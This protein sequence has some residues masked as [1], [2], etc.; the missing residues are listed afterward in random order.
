MKRHFLV[1]AFAIILV[2]MNASV[3]L[4]DDFTGTVSTLLTANGWAAHSSSGSTPM[5]IASP[6]LAYTGYLSSGIGNATSA[7]ANGEDVNKSF[8]AVSSG[9]VYYSFLV[10]TSITT[11]TAG[12]SAHFMQNSSTFHGRFWIRL[13]GT[14]VNFGL[15]KTTAAATWDPTNYAKDTT[16]LVVLKYTFNTGSTTDDAVYMYVDPTLGGAEPSPTVSITT[17]TATDATSISMIGI[18]QWNTGTLARFDGIRVGTSWA[19]VGATAAGATINVAGTLSAFSTVTGTAS[20]Y[21]SYKVSGANLTADI[22][23]SAPASFELCK[24]SGGTY[25]SGLTFTQSGGSVAEQDV[26]VRIAASAGAGSPSG[27]ITHTSTGA[28]QVDKSVSGTVYKTEPTNH[29]TNFIVDTGTPSYSAI[30]AVWDDAT[31]TVVPDGYLVKGS[32][33]GYSS[34]TAPSDGTA[35]A[36]AALVKNVAAL[37]ET[38][39]FTGLSENTTYYFKI[40]PYTNSGTY[41]NYKVD[42]T[43]PSDEALTGYG[44]PAA[45]TANTASAI[46]HEGFTAHWNAVSGATSYRLDVLTGSTTEILNTG[47]EG[48]TSFPDGWTQNSSYVANNSSIAYAG[49][50]YSGMNGAN[51]YFYTPVLSSP[52]TISFWTEA[53]SATADNTVK[54]QYSSDASSWYDLATYIAD[55]SNTGD[56]IDTWAQKTVQANLTGSYYIRWFMSARSGGSQYFDEILITSGSSSFVSGWNNRA[57]NNT[58]VRVPNLSAST[59]YTYRVRAVNDSGTSANS[60]TI[61]VSTTAVVTGTGASTSINGGSTVVI[62]PAVSGLTNNSIEI[63]PSSSSSD[64]FAVTV[65]ASTT[66]VVYNI[67]GSDAAL[68]GLYWLNHAGLSFT[69]TK[70][71]VNDGTVVDSAFDTDESF[72]EITDFGAKG[73]LIITLS[74]DEVLPV[75]LSSFSAVLNSQNNVNILW[76]TQTETS[77]TGF[78]ILRANSADAVDAEQISALI[79]PTNTSQQQTYVYT[80]NSLVEAGTYYYWL[81]VAEMDGNSALHGPISISYNYQDNPGTPGIDLVTELKSVY[82]NPFN[83]STTISYGIAKAADVNFAI[84][85]ARGQLV[86]SVSK[87]VQSPDNY[88]LTW[89][90]KDNNGKECSTGIYYIKMSAGKDSFVRKAVLM[91]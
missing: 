24:T 77:L 55:G 25:T 49:T 54:L 86:R 66:S 74:E 52:T 26:F 70:V 35:E 34:I 85:N 58:I 60:N 88:K 68:S 19:D 5:S 80:D 53:S 78:Y 39:S 3:L 20:A 81:Q 84:Y 14:D 45:P 12:Y 71:T 23:V 82:P 64:D 87:G 13:V 36:D 32:S 29:V 62:V 15:A 33:V 38:T 63:D 9:S 89:N 40:Y 10:N 48:S 2:A 83:P 28:T 72:V 17:D 61:E 76:V 18:R 75:E 6:G 69:P 91:K 50:Y 42:G 27:N 44:P 73:T 7:S 46:S 67:T 51:D 57:V 37:S 56:V 11:T 90:G 8:T 30:D 65:T 43:V 16:Y 1:L 22:S 59:D 31:G 41:I 79:D 4:T 47:F 21:Q